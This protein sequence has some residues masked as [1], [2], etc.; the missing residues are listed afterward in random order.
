MVADD[1]YLGGVAIIEIDPPRDQEDEVVVG[2][3]I[4]LSIKRPDGGTDGPFTPVYDAALDVYAYTYVPS[5]SGAHSWRAVVSGTGS[6]AAEGAFY[7]YP[8]FAILTD[9]WKPALTDVAAL[10]PTRTIDSNGTQQNT[11]TTLTTPTATQVNGYIAQ[12]VAEVVGVA[13]EIPAAV[14]AQAKG[15]ASLGV[16]WLV[17]RSYPPTA[18]VQSVA[19]DFVTDYRASLRLLAQSARGA[20]SGGRAVSMSLGSFTWPDR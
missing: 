5:A 20:E 3:T 13:G 1:I 2:P 4:A 15:V 12:I 10:V 14:F 19:N 7:V 9:A 18:D 6:G 11:F 8:A 17:E 16:A